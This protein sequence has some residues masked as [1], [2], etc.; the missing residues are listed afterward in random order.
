MHRSALL[1]LGI[2]MGALAIVAAPSAGVQPTMGGSD[3]PTFQP[4]AAAQTGCAGCHADE[5]AKGSMNPATCANCH[6]QEAMGFNASIHRRT[7]HADVTCESC[8][9]PPEGGWYEHFRE[10]PHGSQN[11]G[12]SVTPEETCANCHGAENAHSPVY[13]EW[14]ETADP[15][16][17]VLG[18]SHSKRPSAA[19][20]T[21]ECMPCH[22]THEGVFANIEQASGVY[23]YARAAQPDPASVTEWRITCSVCH[24]PHN[25]TETDPLRGSFEDGSTLCAQ[26]HNAELGSRLQNPEH[27]VVHHS[28]WGLY[29]RSKFATNESSHVELDCYSCHMASR[30]AK[31]RN[32]TIL[33]RAITGHSFEVNSTLLQDPSQLEAPAYRQCGT[34]HRNLAETMTNEQRIVGSFLEVTRQLWSEANTTITRYDMTDVPEIRRA[35]RNG[36]FWMNFVE[37]A[38][39]GL[40]NPEMAIGRLRRAIVRFDRVKSLAYQREIESLRTQINET[41]GVTGV[42]KGS[43]TPTTTEASSP[44]TTGT[45]TTETTTPAVG[46]AGVL[47]SLIA[48]VLLLGWRRD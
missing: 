28:M 18:A 5:R 36:T 3:G 43:P 47:L 21:S 46:V 17:S 42:S 29:S 40:H 22:G 31:S 35:M 26:C 45:G 1:L 38:G 32:G 11:P 8:H 39:A 13:P 4:P 19:V 2:A 37:G 27:T 34:C 24:E 15:G 44:T 20:K 6:P 33:R 23:E 9:T 30:E 41:R 25:I 7:Q 12:V 16:W 48:A 14:N 10:G